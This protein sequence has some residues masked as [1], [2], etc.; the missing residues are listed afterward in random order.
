VNFAATR[1][2]ALG[3]AF[4]ELG[5]RPLASLVGILAMATAIF[6]AVLSGLVVSRAGAID[7]P[8]WSRAEALVLA[9]GGAGEVDLGAIRAALARV[10]GVASVEFVGRD[11]ALA[12]LAQRKGLAVLNLQ[13]LRPNPLPDAFVVRFAPGIAPETV[14]SAVAALARQKD[15]ESVEYQPETYR[16][17]SALADLARRAARAGAGWAA[18]TLLLAL[19]LGHALWAAPPAA[20]VRVL[21]ML[22]AESGVIG[23]TYAYAGALRAG[24]AAALAW[25]ALLAGLAWL[26]P[27]LAAL[28][29]RYGM[30]W[31]PLAPPAALGAGVVAGAALLGGVLASLR[32]RLAIRGALG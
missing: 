15:V 1:P 8:A 21:H 32:A 4:A 26:E 31:P 24:L 3:E 27:S 9:A 10:D 6:L 5:R 25:G 28:A 2:A 23:R 30:A 19:S 17:L 14:E 29:Q 18:L 13:E 16:R 11:A 20:D 12:Q 22:G 7:A